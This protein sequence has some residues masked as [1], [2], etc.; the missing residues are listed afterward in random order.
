MLTRGEFALLAAF[1]RN[2]GRVLSRAQ[3]RNAIDGR[4][5]DSYDR[6]IDM[7]VARLRRKLESEPAKSRFIVTVP[8]IGYKFVPRVQ[9]ANVIPPPPVVPLLPDRTTRH[10]LFVE[11]RQCNVL[12]CQ[13]LGFATL[14]ANLDPEDLV[15]TISRVY[16]TCDETIARF[17]G[18]MV[19]CLGDHVLAY[20]GHPKAL[21]DDAE[22]AVR[23][24]L[25]LL[26]TAGS[27]EV[28]PFGRLRARIGIATG[29]MLVGEL[30]SGVTKEPSIMGE[31]LNLA[32]H[33][34]QAAPADYVVSESRTCD[35]IGRRF[36][37]RKLEPI[38]LDEGSDPTPA[39]RVIDEIASLPRFDALRRDDMLELVGREA[40]IERLSRF[41]S[42]ARGGSGKVVVL[43]GEAG[44]GK[45][46]LIVE[47]EDR[48]HPEPDDV[49]RYSGSP[50]QTEAPM[51]AL[52]G[53]LER[54]AGFANDD[55]PLQKLE[56]LRRSFETLGPV[57]AEA[58]LLIS[59]LLD[60]PSE[61]SAEAAHL[62]PQKRRERIFAMLLARIEA[63]ASHRPMLAVVED[64]Q[65]VDPTS[66]EFL[67][68]V[69]ARAHALRL[70]LVIVGRPEFAPPWPDHS[71]ISTITLSR[72]S[73]SNSAA[74]IQQ[75]AGDHRRVP[76]LI[77]AEIVARADGVPL[78]VEELAKSVLERSPNGGGPMLLRAGE[79]S[80]PQ[81]IPMT[82]H[83]LLVARL[84]RLDGGKE[85]AQAGAV[86]GR[87]FSYELLRTITSMDE[88][89]L[90]AALDRLVSSGLVF[91][92]GATPQATFVFKHALVCDAAY[93]ILSRQQRQLLH[94]SVAQAYEDHFAGTAETQP[95]LLAYHHKEAGNPAKAVGY[96]LP[97]AER[98]LHRSA[99]TE[100][101][102]HLAQARELILG[103][104]ENRN[105]LE[106]E[107]KLEITL[108]RALLASRGYTAPETH[109]A[110]RRARHCCEALGDQASLPLIIHGQWL[111]AWVAADHP[112]ALEEAARLHLWGERNNEDAGLTVGHTDIGMTLTTLGQLVEAR[113]HLD[114]ALRINKFVLPGRQPFVASNEDGRISALSFMHNCLLLL[115]FPDQAEAAAREA[116]SL[117][118]RNLYSRVLA[119]LRIMRMQVFGRDPD[120]IP[121]VALDIMHMAE[122]QGYPYFI[123]AA[124]IF[125][126]WALARRGDISGGIEFC[127]RGLAQLEAIG[128]KSWLP[129]HLALLVECY[130]QAGDTERGSQAVA[131]ALDGVEATGERIWESEIYRL[132][133]KLL[134]RAGETGAAQACFIEALQKARRQNARLLELRAAVSLA[135]LL[136][137]NSKPAQ[138]R[139][140]L[141]PVY[142][143]FTEGFD[144]VDVR[145]ARVFLDS[146]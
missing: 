123:G 134:L 58:T 20:F 125:M 72:L 100:A 84:D 21:E 4:A 102:S 75:I 38:V 116:A 103:L 132:K 73:R 12:S 76:A 96:L 115:G 91:R 26:Q 104:P 61:P 64:V 15:H 44:I 90:A 24:A 5:A 71:Y 145:E 27:I 57:C 122:E 37:C 11:R 17:N 70:L 138:A 131:Q 89:T 55:D 46:R 144:F 22:N 60:L 62:S 140:A 137:R 32:L 142:A 95:E 69:V 101:L 68:L 56:K 78:F 1:A 113:R 139:E 36:D 124:S 74:L 29:L 47:L 53:E 54:S 99:T 59:G 51:A 133:G 118:P 80:G 41:W 127:R 128:A 135:G 141:A 19:R 109:E 97:A 52:L 42:E 94:A 6:S 67:T 117:N 16:T 23:A 10:P 114:Q 48:L 88:R 30:N 108:A 66:M 143:S 31:A 65:W 50:H 63:M 107:L 45:S 77:E 98:A 25:E 79:R 129:V 105:R 82:L 112:T 85:V 40:E 146:L 2:P 7:L 28:A 49:I 136:K 87:E 39:W 18:T 33:M 34:Q 121:D 13:I 81:S 106:L 130:E 35:L 83:G 119:Q 8:G 3:L 126:G 9:T 110:Y 93:A 111:G 43:T 92:R 14:A 86:I 120:A